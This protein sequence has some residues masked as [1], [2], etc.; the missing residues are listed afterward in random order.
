MDVAPLF[1]DLFNK[2]FVIDKGG[3]KFWFRDYVNELVE[4][5]LA[6]KVLMEYRQCQIGWRELVKTWAEPQIRA[7]CLNMVRRSLMKSFISILY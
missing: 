4:Y 2:K 3:A 7:Q 6:Q 5:G 1:V